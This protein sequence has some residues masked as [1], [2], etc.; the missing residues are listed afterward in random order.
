MNDALRLVELFFLDP[1]IIHVAAWWAVLALVG[2]AFLPLAVRL[3]GAA[4]CG[5]YLFARVIG[6]SA[7]SYAAWLAASLGL[8]P[9]T[10]ASAL[11]AV[12]ACAALNWLHRGARREALSLLAARRRDVLLMEYMFV[13]GFLACAMIRSLRPEI[14]GLEKFLD[15]GYINS[16]LRSD[17]MPPVDMWMAGR[18]INYYYFGHFMTA[19]VCRLSGTPAEVGFN[20]M[21]STVFALAFSLSYSLVCG[22][23]RLV[24]KSARRAVAG[25]MLAAFLMVAGAHLQPFIY[26]AVLPLMKSAGL[27]QGEVQAYWYPSASRFIGHRPPT[28]DKTIHEFPAYAFAVADLHAHVLDTPL[29]LAFAGVS[30]SMLATASPAASVRPPWREAFAGILLGVSWMTN[31][32]DYPLYLAILAV[33]ALL[34]A[35]A[36][37]G[38]GRRVILEALAAAA[39]LV[40]VSQAAILPYMRAF[41]FMT[42][43][44]HRVMANS[45]LWQLS[46]LWGYQGFFALC[47]ALFMASEARRRARGGG[48]RAAAAAPPQDLFVLGL[49]AAAVCLVIIPEVVYVKDIYGKTFHR[50]N[51]MFKLAYQAAVLFN[52]AVAYTA[53]RLPGALPGGR[54]RAALGL[55][56]AAV[57]A[58]PL[59]YFR[60]AVPGYYGSPRVDP[61]RYQWLD[62]LAFLPEGDRAMVRWLDEN[63]Q[64]RPAILESDGENYSKHGRISM[65]TGLPAVLGWR[66]H[67]WS[68]R[69]DPVE[70]GRRRGIVRRVYESSAPAEARDLLREFGVRYVIVG[71]LERESYP[72]LDEK[73]L[74]AMGREAY[75]TP[76]GTGVIIEL[77][78]DPGEE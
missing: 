15:L 44:V 21:F 11:A 76:D 58:M 20:L 28:D 35:L 36:R 77:D 75:R 73:T 41:Q 67:T 24:Q 10:R 40:A 57:V 29:S 61:A 45:P 23:L 54:R 49:F 68:M 43:G 78:E 64:G 39:V 52:L 50:A 56:F 60:W 14:S 74:I 30:A 5:G 65:A 63:A 32:W 38:P 37:H 8:S 25:G 42:E 66:G 53:V 62:G 6:L 2:L 59:T 27:Y 12:A 34:A 47:F 33:S 4:A 22:L 9:L 31:S 71:G 51:T 16:V 48:L 3:F 70:P 17:V 55:L 26:G 19:F 72:G 46:I 69:G 7:A 1:G 13:A 18:P